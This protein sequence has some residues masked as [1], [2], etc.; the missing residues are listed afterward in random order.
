MAK[1]LPP[2][3]LKEDIEKYQ[4][5]HEEKEVVFQGCKHTGITFDKEKHQL[6]CVCGVAFSGERLGELYTALTKQ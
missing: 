3:D 4:A 1:N 2:L 5:F 6:R